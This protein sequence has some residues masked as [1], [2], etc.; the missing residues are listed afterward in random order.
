MAFM[1]KAYGYQGCHQINAFAMDVT[2]ALSS[3]LT[4]EMPQ[5]HP[6][7]FRSFSRAS[8]SGVSMARRRFSATFP[9]FRVDRH[10]ADALIA[11]DSD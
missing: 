6:I 5:P 7:L 2:T 8:Q 9:L 4:E 3:F 10:L 1:R 11:W